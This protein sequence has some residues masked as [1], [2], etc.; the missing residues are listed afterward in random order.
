MLRK[1]FIARRVP[2]I[3]FRFGVRPVAPAAV[4]AAAKPSASPAV[5]GSIS[6]VYESMWD[7]PAN[8]RPKMVSE[9]EMDFIRFGGASPYAP[10]KPSKG[11][12]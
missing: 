11:K 6:N 1:T 4:A 2:M 5:D 8:L 3:Q 12:K 9:E 7:L 10:A